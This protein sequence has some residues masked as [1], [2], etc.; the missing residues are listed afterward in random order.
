MYQTGK[1]NTIDATLHVGD[2]N[3]SV[4]PAVV[5]A[6]LP[7]RFGVRSMETISMSSRLSDVAVP[8]SMTS[9]ER[10]DAV[11]L[12]CDFHLDHSA[13]VTQGKRMRLPTTSQNMTSPWTT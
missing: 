1:A 7:G 9:Y 5:G 2:K 3:Q 4:C 6:A 13:P 10:A 12:L 8:T 11:M